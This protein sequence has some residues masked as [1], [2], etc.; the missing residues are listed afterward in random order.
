M[1]KE[2]ADLTEL[3][4]SL[5]ARVEVLER[6]LAQIEAKSANNPMEVEPRPSVV[7]LGQEKTI[8]SMAKTIGDR[9]Q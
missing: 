6:R 1:D 2:L 5:T 3:V 7:W 8:G 9:L 4:D